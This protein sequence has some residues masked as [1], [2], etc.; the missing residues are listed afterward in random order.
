MPD[1]HTLHSNTDAF[2]EALDNLKK[3][4]KNMFMPEDTKI[5]TATAEDGQNTNSVPTKI[6]RDEKGYT[7]W[8]SEDKIF[9]KPRT[10]I[11][12]VLLTKP[13]ENGYPV[14]L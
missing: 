12:L 9:R 1:Y 14:Y 3:P 10:S 13:G 2:K 8:L 4:S 6:S 7:L 5:I 11:S